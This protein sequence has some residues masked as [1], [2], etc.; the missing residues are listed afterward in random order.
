MTKF[1]TPENTRNDQPILE[2][3][4]LR[5]RSKER[6]INTFDS[7]D[8]IN[9][10]G[11]EGEIRVDLYSL[12]NIKKVEADGS[13]T[14]LHGL[15]LM[16]DCGYEIDNRGKFIA[17]DYISD[18]ITGSADSVHAVLQGVIKVEDYEKHGENRLTKEVAIKCYIKRTTEENLR[19]AINEIETMREQ[20]KRG[21]LTFKPVAL[22]IAPGRYD[23]KETVVILSEFDSTRITMDNITWREGFTE[24][25]IKAAKDAI[26]A[27]A[28]F[29]QQ[30]YKHGDT[31][32]KNIAQTQAGGGTNMIDFETTQKVDLSDINQIMLIAREDFGL[33]IKS[34]NHRNFFSSYQEYEIEDMVN[35]LMQEY[36]MQWQEYDDETQ[37]VVINGLDEARIDFLKFREHKK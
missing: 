13:T 4:S 3:E 1:R 27:L 17:L 8:A 32:I 35:D 6:L 12:Y 14:Y 10:L 11:A 18:Y 37:D 2:D 24:E 22:M 15:Y 30:G 21:L 29:N 19:R 34:L 36:A 5:T 31:K 9:R 16:P 20:E 7:L 25:N 33:L 28:K 23:D 26:V